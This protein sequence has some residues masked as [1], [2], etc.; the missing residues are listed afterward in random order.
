MEAI[1][2]YAQILHSRAA[3]QL[4]KWR[5]RHRS[6][7]GCAQGTWGSSMT[8]HRHRTPIQQSRSADTSP[9]YL[10]GPLELRRA[11]MTPWAGF[12]RILRR[13]APVCLRRHPGHRLEGFLLPR[14]HCTP[15]DRGHP[16]KP[17]WDTIASGTPWTKTAKPLL[18]KRTPFLRRAWN[19]EQAR[20]DDRAG[21][22]DVAKAG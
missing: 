1:D 10:P 18:P 17:P 22:P 12:A 20:M 7:A 4:D 11:T 21:I 19:L 3:W 8:T 6:A 5:R 9:T 15:S 2:L 13:R 16:A 14:W